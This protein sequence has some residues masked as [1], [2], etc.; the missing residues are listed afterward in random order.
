M[1]LSELE[2]R[3]RRFTLALRA[4]I[5][6]LLLISLVFYAIFIQEGVFKP[7]L[8]NTF[9]IVA[10]IFISVYFNYFM[11]SMSAKETI[12][13]T[14]THSF[15]ERAFIN[16]LQAYRPK[17]LVLLVINNLYTINENY[18]A[19]KVDLLLYTIIQKLNSALKQYG[20]HNPLIGRRY[21]AEFLIALDKDN[22]DV[23]EI[24]EKFIEENK[25]LN[26]IEIDYLFSAVTDTEENIEQVL[27]QLKD[28]ISSNNSEKTPIT[29]VQDAK[30]MNQ[31][32]QDI[33]DALNN[34][35]FNIS[36]RPLVNTKNNQIEL[37]EI[38]SKLLSSEQT[39]ILPRVFL[40]II[41]RLG[42][43][44]TYDLALVEHIIKLLPLVDNKISFTFNLSPFSLRNSGFQEKFFTLLQEHNIESSRLII[45]LYER[46]THHDL[47]GYFKTLTTFRA[48][49][50]RICIDNFGSSNASMEY[51]K[52]FKF[53]MVQ[54]DREYVTNLQ[55]KTNVAM[56]TSLV[57]MSKE[58]NILTV[59]KWV[60]K[61]S[62]KETLKNLGINYLQ[63]FGIDKP[64]N[65]SQLINRYN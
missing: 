16:K 2:E 45:Q 63:G 17:T 15:N 52:H 29:N 41:N 28:L 19:E 36:F 37:Y 33:I 4:S 54:F 51:M 13:D 30:V 39:E 58:L 14:T 50:V 31:T 11:M 18:T 8:I 32:E 5:P 38:A 35:N 25:I 12:I 9:L 61:D 43:G 49:G 20:L 62:Q 60:D 27:G 48:K 3:G 64:I 65:E 59:A 21:G 55:D 53:D 40:P 7:T 44:I 10:I 23:K 22:Y 46:K 26:D 24:F 47:S 56:L 6:V 42:L 34:K 1:L 57:T